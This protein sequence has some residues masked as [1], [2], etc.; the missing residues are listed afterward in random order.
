MT[1]QRIIT[2]ALSALLLVSF[3]GCTDDPPTELAGVLADLTPVPSSLAA[4]EPYAAPQPERDHPYSAALSS[5]A[6]KVYVTL[7]G[8]EAEPGNQ[9]AVISASTLA[10]QKKITVG[11]SPNDVVLHP[12]GRYIV[13]TN[14]FS[15]Y[16]SVIDTE[17]D[18]Q[19]GK[20]P[21]PYYAIEIAFNN[22]G[23]RAWVTNR[24][25]NSV[26]SYNVRTA[27]EGGL[28]FEQ[29]DAPGARVRDQ[30]MGN[31]SIPVGFNPRGIAVDEASGRV[32]VGNLPDLT[33]SVIDIDTDREI[34]TDGNPQ[35]SDLRAPSGV[36]RLNV[37][38]PVS[39]LVV[40][41][42][43]LFVA[44]FSKGTGHPAD[45]GP[46]ADGDGQP[47]DGT[48]NRGFHDLQNEIA[49][50]AT[51]SLQPGVRY[52]SDS[53]LGFFQDAEEGAPG[54][55]PAEERIVIGAVPEQIIAV[56]PTRLAMT[57]SGSGEIS[58]Y[59]VAGSRLTAS[60]SA[61]VG[62]FPYGMAVDQ[63]SG[64]VFVAN[65]LS[66]DI[67]RVTS[68][69]QVEN[70]VIGNVS[71]GSYPATDAEIGEL[72]MF[73]TPLFSADGDTSCEHCHRE[74]GSQQR[75]VAGGVLNSPY[76]MRAT[77][78]SRN[79]LRTNPW[80]F[81][82][83]LDETKFSPQLN[84]MAKEGNFGEG[85][86]LSQYADRDAFMRAKSA[87]WVGR[88]ESFGDSISSRSL[89]FDGIAE[90][91]G[92]AM[93]IEPRLLPNPNALDTFAAE[94]GRTLFNSAQTSCAVCHP[95]PHFAVTRENAAELGLPLEMRMFTPTMY[96]GENTDTLK[97]SIKAEFDIESDLFGVPTL[98]GLWDR[99]LMFYH[100]GRAVT[101]VEALATPDHPA[102][103]PGQRGVNERDGVLDIH[104]GTSHLTA[105]QLDDL[106]E[107]LI[108]I[109]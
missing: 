82:N 80:M 98:R 28:V 60:G 39:D 68:N 31:S 102:L 53:M 72:V 87:E 76:G 106:I 84:R 61:Y 63:A 9:V 108:A 16:M 20:I 10:V 32:F 66:E 35:T 77:P 6:Q 8:N 55:A 44:T 3:A 94:R 43:T 21:T 19:I 29:R 5:D 34:D 48:A 96:E 79:L 104:G 38:A 88:T 83:F 78:M 69:A 81:E 33:V 89:D 37:G 14:R 93:V 12:G 30:L 50:Y 45:E 26:L 22:A 18:E 27:D 7:H 1:T 42:N 47:G 41:G 97:E 52:T 58:F 107:Y 86:P 70:R 13:V 25:L 105:A 100:D 23:D 40:V 103:Q 62:L 64:T 4:G 75:R 59:D 71:G 57:T 17:S 85:A 92:V 65:R 49:T 36:T 90:V 95:A 91:M 73:M 101:W 11:L 74:L 2:R 109:E 99:N 54:L 56:S 15:A 51:S 67:A 24:W 46:D